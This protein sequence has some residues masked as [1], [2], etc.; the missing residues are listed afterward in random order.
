M[1]QGV[2]D[3]HLLQ[4]FERQFAKRPAAGGEHDPPHFL[5]PAGLQA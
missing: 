5:A 2:V 4:L 1:R 3:R